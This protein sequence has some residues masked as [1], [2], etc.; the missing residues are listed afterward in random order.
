MSWRGGQRA[1]GTGVGDAAC[2]DHLGV[3]LGAAALAEAVQPA[4]PDGGLGAAARRV[5]AT[6]ARVAAGS[7]E[8]RP[9]PP[10]QAA[11]YMVYNLALFFYFLFFFCFLL[12]FLSS[13]PFN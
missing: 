5:L 2:A 3:P 11:V 9:T 6:A 7:R 8:R 10:L 1:P 13:L 12:L 4:V